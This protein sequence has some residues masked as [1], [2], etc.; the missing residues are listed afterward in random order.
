MPRCAGPLY[1][2][3]EFAPHGN[4]RD[5][6]KSHRPLG[7]SYSCIVEY[8]RPVV[9]HSTGSSC[10]GTSADP[11]EQ[12]PKTLT[13]KDLISYAYQVARGMEYLASKQVRGKGLP[14]SVCPCLLGLL[15]VPVPAGWLPVWPFL[16]LLVWP[17][18]CLSGRL[19]VS[20]AVCLSVWP[21]ACQSLW[22]FA[23]LTICCVLLRSG[24]VFVDLFVR[25][26]SRPQVHSE[27]PGK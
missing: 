7:S 27:D 22:P 24:S 3:V 14:L 19:S 13:P 16:C 17:F 20:L 21:F 23:W 1:V 6:L 18:V 9:S 11:Q 5:F 12:Q 25:L 26:L 4:L 15:F 8:E 10:P 2:I